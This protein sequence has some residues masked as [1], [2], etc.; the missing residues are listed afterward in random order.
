MSE[1][2]TNYNTN[3]PERKGFITTTTNL[4]S[5]SKVTLK[6]SFQTQSPRKSSPTEQ[7]QQQT[8]TTTRY[9]SSPSSN[10]IISHHPLVGPGSPSSGG[11]TTSSNIN[12]V[13]SHSSTQ[14]TQT[15]IDHHS[16]SRRS[17]AHDNNNLSPGSTAR[18]AVR[19]SPPNRITSTPGARVNASLVQVIQSPSPRSYASVREPF[20]SLDEEFLERS[21]RVEST[22]PIRKRDRYEPGKQHRSSPSATL[23]GNT[24]TTTSNANANTIVSTSTTSTVVRE[25][26]P[27]RRVVYVSRS[28]SSNTNITS[29][30]INSS[31][32]SNHGLH[33]SPQH[34]PIR[35]PS[36]VR[37]RKDDESRRSRYIERYEDHGGVACRSPQRV[38]QYL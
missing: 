1:Y 34:Q 18:L 24:T 25:S 19:S 2:Y 12:P 37:V 15:S 7:L 33:V 32:S 11:L 38:R 22:S 5:T 21:G 10:N 20:H 3:K 30:S 26:S 23:Y 9:L 4:P 14:K 27:T 31:S 36:P 16:L 6:G 8:Q 13:F 17:F 29:V 35:E 28:P